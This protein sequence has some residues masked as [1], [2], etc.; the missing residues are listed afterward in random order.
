MAGAQSRI[1]NE[2]PHPARSARTPRRR[3]IGNAQTNESLLIANPRSSARMKEGGERESRAGGGSQ[4]IPNC[5][6]ANWREYEDDTLR[7]RIGNR[8]GSH[9]E[10][11]HRQGEGM[12]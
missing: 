10:L 2:Y 12:V 1:A 3:D 6:R 4:Y 9:W 11:P 7:A 8:P 5:L